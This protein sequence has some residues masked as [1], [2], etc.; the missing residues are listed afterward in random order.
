[1]IALNIMLLIFNTIQPLFFG[2]IID[3]VLHKK[4]NAIIF[5][6]V[7]ILILNIISTGLNF[8][9]SRLATNISNK[10]E[11]NVKSNIFTSIINMPL[12]VLDKSQKGEFF[13]KIDSDV[14]EFTK[15]LLYTIPG[16]LND[17]ISAISVGIIIFKINI[18][19]SLIIFIS[20]PA[21]YFL[22]YIYG[23]KMRVNSEN[24]KK[25]QDDYVTKVQEYFSG[26]KTIKIF[27]AEKY[28]TDKYSKTLNSYYNIVKKIAFTNYEGSFIAQ[29]I[30]V[31]SNLL[32][33][34][35]G[36]YEVVISKI[37]LGN[38]V[39]INSYSSS[40]VSSLFKISQI[41]T[42]IQVSIVSLNRVLSVINSYKN[43]NSL[44]AKAINRNENI[45]DKGISLKDLSFRYQMEYEQVLKNVNLTIPPNKITVIKGANGCGK[46][47]LLNLLMGLY[48][49]YTGRIIVGGTDYKDI[50]KEVILDSFN[51][52]TQDVFLFSGTIKDN[53]LLGNQIT[54]QKLNEICKLVNID[55]FIDSLSDKFETC[56]ENN[57]MKLSGGQ[58]Q[59]ISIARAIV[60]NKRIYLFDEITSS[61]DKETEI[62]IL[63]LIKQLSQNNTIIIVSHDNKI[64][65]YA[66]YVIDIEQCNNL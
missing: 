26:I 33:L 13:V 43:K 52:V 15:I 6:I 20:F 27:N 17:L 3:N 30:N 51:Y 29:L 39:A 64:I 32:F 28:F 60:R 66:D 10:I 5:F 55:D 48:D 46:S 24:F 53:I 61:L 40:F 45:F 11:M 18:E 44:G 49:N 7:L 62:S 35:F 54:D 8:I 56:I 47:T 19:L 23:K 65:N 38:L 14:S 34:A 25:E 42:N 21:S 9:S 31:I 16:I 36:T 50:P 63:K 1:M 59:K 12:S 4:I 58:K 37:T 22:Y 57:N 41:N 2:R